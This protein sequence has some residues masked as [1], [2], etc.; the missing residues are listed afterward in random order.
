MTG[1]RRIKIK[2]HVTG[3]E[4][5]VRWHEDR[6]PTDWDIQYII[7]QRHARPDSV[8][9]QLTK[10]D[11]DILKAES[12]LFGEYEIPPTSLPG[13]VINMAK[14]A[15]ARVDESAEEVDN[16][17]KQLSQDGLLELPAKEEE[18]RGALEKAK[19]PVFG[20]FEDVEDA[21]RKRNPQ[22]HRLQQ[23]AEQAERAYQATGS[24]EM[25]ERQIAIIQEQ[26]ARL[27]GV[28]EAL[29]EYETR[30]GE[31]RESPEMQDMLERRR[32]Y[33]E[34]LIENDEKIKLYDRLTQRM[35]ELVPEVE[36][37]KEP[38]RLGQAALYLL[39]GVTSLWNTTLRLST[40]LT[41]LAST[42]D[43]FRHDR[44]LTGSMR[45]GLEPHEW[46]RLVEDTGEVIEDFV[47]SIVNAF[48]GAFVR[49]W[50]SLPEIHLERIGA[51]L[52]EVG[53]PTTSMPLDRWMEKV[54]GAFEQTGE[55]QLATLYALSPAISTDGETISINDALG[56]LIEIRMPEPF[57]KALGIAGRTGKKL[58]RGYVLSRLAKRDKETVGKVSKKFL[59][60]LDD[61][62]RKLTPDELEYYRRRPQEFYER[63]A[64][65]E[66]LSPEAR[67][68]F[69]ANQKAVSERLKVANQAT[70]DKQKLRDMA[71]RARLADPETGRPFPERPLPDESTWRRAATP[72]V[73]TI[74][75]HTAIPEDVQ[76]GLREIGYSQ[77]QINKMSGREG[78]TIL[79]HK[80][81]PGQ[82][83]P[84]PGN[85]MYDTHGNIDFR[86]VPTEMQ[87]IVRNYARFMKDEI[88]SAV[89]TKGGARIDYGVPGQ[90]GTPEVR[91]WGATSTS[92]PWF[93]TLTPRRSHRDVSNALQ[94]V[95][96]GK[97]RSPLAHKLADMAVEHLTEG[98]TT[99]YGRIPADEQFNR[100]FDAYLSGGFGVS[101]TVASR[102]VT[103][104]E[105][106]S[107]LDSSLQ[108]LVNSGYESYARSIS[109]KP[110]YGMAGA[111]AGFDLEIEDGEI[112]AIGFDAQRGLYG[113]ALGMGALGMMS[114]SSRWGKFFSRIKRDPK[115]AKE[116]DRKIKFSTER[117]RGNKLAKSPQ[118]KRLSDTERVMLRATGSDGFT[119]QELV[120]F[121]RT[122]K[123]P[124]SVWN[125]VPDE[126]RPAEHPKQFVIGL[127]TKRE[128]QESIRKAYLTD[129]SGTELER[130]SREYMSSNN[131][132]SAINVFGTPAVKRQLISALERGLVDD[133]GSYTLDTLL[134]AQRADKGH[135]MGPLRTYI[136]E[137]F[138]STQLARFQWQEQA[139]GLLDKA[140]GNIKK[141]TPEEWLTTHVAEVISHAERQLDTIDVGQIR[142]RLANLQNEMTT[143][144]ANALDEMNRLISEG[145]NIPR[146]KVG[147]RFLNFLQVKT[148]EKQLSRIDDA[149]D[150]LSRNGISDEVITS[151][152]RV[153]KLL[154]QWRVDMNK[155]NAKLG[156]REIPLLD[157]YVPEIRRQLFLDKVARDELFGLSRTQKYARDVWNPRA[158]ERL[159]GIP[160]EERQMGLIGLAENYARTTSDVLWTN[161]LVRHMKE[162]TKLFRDMGYNRLAEFWDDWTNMGLLGKNPEGGLR[163]WF[164]QTAPIIN[165]AL[166]KH[167]EWMA[168]T[169]FDL[170]IQWNLRT[171]TSSWA[172]IPTRMG[173]NNTAKALRT[174]AQEATRPQNERHITNFVNE[175]YA[176][177]TKVRGSGG[178]R[179]QDQSVYAQ[180]YHVLDKTR[181]EKARDAA[182]YFT[183]YTEARLSQWA[184][185]AGYHKWYDKGFRGKT[186]RALV[187]EEVAKTQSMYNTL[188]RPMALWNNLLTASFPF[189]TFSFTVMN[190]MREMAWGMTFRGDRMAAV[191]RA[192]GAI[193]ATNAAWSFMTGVSP[194][195]ASAFMPFFGP[196]FGG[197]AN[198]ISRDI[199]Y[200]NSGFGMMDTRNLPSPMSI[201]FDFYRGVS[202]F[203]K[204]G[205]YR[206]LST[207]LARWAPAPLGWT[208]GVQWSRMVDAA[209]AQARN[210]EMRDVR[211][212]TL[213]TM[214]SWLD[215]AY[216]FYAGPWGTSPG[217]EY[218]VQRNMIPRFS[219][220]FYGLRYD[221]S[222][223]SPT[224]GTPTEGEREIQERQMIERQMIERQMR[225]R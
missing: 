212:N 83:L 62:K 94:Q 142:T 16:I 199:G 110:I 58:S 33:E 187:S 127:H 29:R 61:Y 3:E 6:D 185:V 68:V 38:S 98:T 218:K 171:Q 7:D 165:R 114:T 167:K 153:S 160:Y 109:T 57:L 73:P 149:I 197:V 146:R 195:S 144:R 155:M 100:L 135:V 104:A 184:G 21:F 18:L 175:T 140:R 157:N 41:K 215:A 191:L 123:I 99:S 205:D 10:R 194:W 161:P 217:N 106:R 128:F 150:H 32:D 225:E 186:L 117:L 81:K 8:D 120:D 180:H 72:E 192:F 214:D 48:K 125:R 25:Y 208:A 36:Q 121:K 211:G 203:A 222:M 136:Y 90:G 1:G 115:F 12:P 15:R 96:D 190:T 30:I 130:L 224:G 88:D 119:R 23:L 27:E 44:A 97:P 40:N 49:D 66:M 148:F 126:V 28:E 103:L 174:M 176:F 11:P 169:V 198:Y 116:V 219:R 223:P 39:G 154:D 200:D 37:P 173:Y 178:L 79:T 42:A 93:R 177:Q 75:K 91:R 145:R 64:Q 56:L 122:G 206:R 35:Q 210:G 108:N 55:P 13:I 204:H 102:P 138:T 77:E 166:Q 196:I 181:L 207:S 188:D 59:Q 143:R 50:E 189:Q 179:F 141:N 132:D 133:Y 220:Y 54:W 201:G 182:S 172:L 163:K 71:Q 45:E 65:S 137:P 107:I 193:T 19:E 159:G 202:D 124:Q 89:V 43:T 74:I 112:K 26:A 170:N 209:I 86:K 85:F 139:S 156:I 17:V 51:S 118:Y 101:P 131:L 14:Q 76:R 164:P 46:E 4:F 5:R 84:D 80:L 53:V 60:D 162:H 158:M 113:M 95:V 63:L 34:F 111:F 47:P 213:F 216:S 105:Q 67:A 221:L 147:D 52:T 129:K 70:P 2:D 151:A 22:L 134:N 82:E 24:E 183:N 152:H 78:D 168:R 9:E 31:I 20:A 87:D 69:V 92:P